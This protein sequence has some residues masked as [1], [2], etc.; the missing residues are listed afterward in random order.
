MCWL[1]YNLPLI[2]KCDGFSPE[3]WKQMLC[4]TPK[5]WGMSFWRSASEH[6][7]KVS[8]PSLPLLISL[9]YFPSRASGACNKDMGGHRPQVLFHLLILEATKSMAAWSGWK[10]WLNFSHL[11]VTV[12]NNDLWRQWRNAVFRKVN[13]SVQCLA[14]N[15]SYVYLTQKYLCPV[16]S[17][18][19]A[20]VCGL[21]LQQW[22][23]SYER[24]RTMHQELSRM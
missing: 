18:P 11:S 20:Y 21:L 13:Q 23:W 1:K 16:L 17:K 15:R 2:I 5:Q 8:V 12:N 19:P 6:R 24:I 22:I 9:A 7:I 14:F 4:A 10:K 3:R